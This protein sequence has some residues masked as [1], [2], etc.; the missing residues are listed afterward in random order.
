MAAGLRFDEPRIAVVSNVT[1]ELACG[2]LADPGYWV[3][4]VREP[5]RFADGIRAGRR[6][7]VTRFFELGPDGVLTAMA[8]TTLDDDDPGVMFAAA[9]RARQPEPETFAAFLGQAHIAGT[10]VDWQAFYAGSGARRVHLPT[11]AFQRE[12]YWLL[13]GTR[14]D[15]AAAGLG[16]FAHPVLTAAVQVG[17]RDEWLFTGRL[18]PVAAVGRRPRDRASCSRVRLWSSWPS[19]PGADREPGGGGTGP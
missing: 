7:G 15:P 4:H 17:D 18:S 16:R 11:Y 9:L 19:R 12:R 14:G 5:V 6:A 10:A 3:E 2:E 8:R 1:G 13:P